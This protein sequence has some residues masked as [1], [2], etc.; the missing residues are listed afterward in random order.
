MYCSTIFLRIIF[1][2]NDNVDV[3]L[4]Q[5]VPLRKQLGFLNMFTQIMAVLGSQASHYLPRLLKI[6]FYCLRTSRDCLGQ[7][8][9]VRNTRCFIEF[10]SPL[11]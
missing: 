5:V 10:F 7:R 4:N 8:E 9:K 6:L 11:N 3:C 1:P 2:D